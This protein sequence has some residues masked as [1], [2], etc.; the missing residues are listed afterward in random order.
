MSSTKSIIAILAFSLLGAVAWTRPE[1]V[2]KR[3]PDSALVRAKLARVTGCA[4]EC[5]HYECALTSFH[6]NGSGSANYGPTHACEGPYN[7]SC[8]HPTCGGETDDLLALADR[9]IALEPDDIDGLRAVLRRSHVELN[10]ER[11]A[12]QF[13]SPCTGLVAAQVDLDSDIA[14]TLAA[15]AANTK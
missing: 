6:A 13:I 3:S 14:A 10:L 2:V 5:A 15:D 7:D 1:I 11:S 12:L 4:N 8:P 9:T